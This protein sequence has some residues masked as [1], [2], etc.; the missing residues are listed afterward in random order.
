MFLETPRFP[1]DVTYEFEGGP[2]FSTE[3]VINAGGYESRNQNWA[4]ARRSWRCNHAPKDR[5]LTDVLTAFFHVT[6]GKAH[7]FRFRDWTDY[8]ATASQGVFVAIN[9][10]TYQMHK[11]YGAGAFS[12][13]RKIVKPVLGTITVTGGSGVS[14]NHAT[15]I[16]TVASGAPTAWAGEFDTP[17][18]FDSDEMRLQVVQT[19]PRRYVWGDI[20][21]TEIRA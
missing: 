12:H 19:S 8:E 17:A 9:A 20:S 11:R 3:V 6:N 2:A 21:L 18:R 1:D 14:I 13:D 10:T 16:V 4:Q 5:A 7:G 15:G